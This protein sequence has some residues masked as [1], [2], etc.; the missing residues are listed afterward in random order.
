MRLLQKQLYW[1]LS[2][3]AIFSKQMLT[4][5]PQPKPVWSHSLFIWKKASL[6][7]LG[8]LLSCTRRGST[9]PWF[10]EERW[11]S[12][13]DI[14]HGNPLILWFAATI[15][16]LPLFLRMLFHGSA[17]ITC[18]DIIFHIS[19]FYILAK[20]WLDGQHG[21]CIFLNKV[22][23]HHAWKSWMLGSSKH[24]PMVSIIMYINPYY[25][26]CI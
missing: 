16:I 18:W 5:A 26:T 11:P 4:D 1:Y 21:C 19:T 6:P 17:M 13:E 14:L 25:M 20:G 7:P 24:H 8:N 12:W 9:K 15:G 10:L 22:M 3:S 2:H 23:W